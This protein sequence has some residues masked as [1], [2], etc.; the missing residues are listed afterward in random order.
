MCDTFIRM[1]SFYTLYIF[2]YYTI[3]IPL[4]L[5]TSLIRYVWWT[6]IIKFTFSLAETDNSLQPGMAP[7]QQH[8]RPPQFRH[9]LPPDVRPQSPGGIRIMNPNIQV[10]IGFACCTVGS[11]DNFWLITWFKV[12]AH[13]W[14]IFKF[15]RQKRHRNLI[16]WAWKLVKNYLGAKT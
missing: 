15:S 2:Y 3:I 4:V 14:W 5:L 10:C 11:I 13:F 7:M 9:P 1:Y 8:Q 12:W 6:T 16:F